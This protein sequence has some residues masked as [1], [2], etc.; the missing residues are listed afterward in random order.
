MHNLSIYNEETKKMETFKGGII[1]EEIFYEYNSEF[2]INAEN[3]FT[4]VL[5]SKWKTIYDYLAN[6]KNIFTNLKIRFDIYKDL[7]NSRPLN[8]LSIQQIIDIGLNSTIKEYAPKEIIIKNKEKNDIFYLIIKGRV[9]VKHPLTNKTLRIY[10]EGNCFGCYLILNESPSDKNYISHQYTKCY[11]LKS[12]KF[13]E[14]LKINTFNDYIKNKLLLEDDEMQLNDF[15]YIS[16]LGK[17][18]LVMFV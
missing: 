12:E 16:Y 2:I 11:C 17:A 9:K 8:N 14:F 15:Y 6:A 1:L 10:E 13:Y 4:L 5:E 3:S 18:P 7:I